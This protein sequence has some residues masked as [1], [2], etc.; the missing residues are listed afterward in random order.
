MRV[1][2]DFVSDLFS[3]PFYSIFKLA[4]TVTAVRPWENYGWTT[5]KKSIV[6]LKISAARVIDSGNYTC[7]PTTAE[8]A[9]VTVHI[10]NGECVNFLKIYCSSRHTHTR[11]ESDKSYAKRWESSLQI[12]KLIDC[13]SGSFDGTKNDAAGKMNTKYEKTAQE[14]II[15]WNAKQWPTKRENGFAVRQCN[16]E[17]GKRVA[18]W[19]RKK[20][21]SSGNWHIERERECSSFRIVWVFWSFE[22]KMAKSSLKVTKWKCVCAEHVWCCASNVDG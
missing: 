5:H 2:S 8:G 1:V 19:H 15:L 18:C 21:V 3:D 7:L 17:R 4:A 10:I 20:P 11:D 16:R 9:S 22:R 6:R 13:V 14:K 12:N